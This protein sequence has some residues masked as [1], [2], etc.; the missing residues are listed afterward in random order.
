MIND[1]DI[2]EV[3]WAQAIIAVS[4]PQII[5]L[6]GSNLKYFR[7]LSLIKMRVDIYANENDEFIYIAYN[8]V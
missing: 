1:S 8:V 3:L 5:S 7:K 6:L 2:C 4:S